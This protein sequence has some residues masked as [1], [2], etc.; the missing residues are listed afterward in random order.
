MEENMILNENEL[1]ESEVIEDRTFTE[2]EVCEIIE[3][4][5]PKV[6]LDVSD[7]ADANIDIEECKRGIKETSFMCGQFVAL[8]SVGLTKEQ[9][10]NIVLNESTGRINVEQSKYQQ[11]QAMQN[12]I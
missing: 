6:Q 4:I 3:E 2:D 8:M 9:A 12:Q 7:L 5:M 10:Y 1:E 11:L